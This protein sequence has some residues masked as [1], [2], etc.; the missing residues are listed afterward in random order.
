MEE[1]RRELVHDDREEKKKRKNRGLVKVEATSSKIQAAPVGT[2]LHRLW[3]CSCHNEA[4][5]R[6]GEPQ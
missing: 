3:E 4:R 2:L 6:E 1:Q 5:K